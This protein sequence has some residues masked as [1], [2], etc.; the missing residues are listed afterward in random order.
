MSGTPRNERYG[1]SPASRKYLNRGCSV[2]SA[3]RLRP[4]LLGDQPG[5]PFGE[6]HPHAADALG[7]QADRRRQHQVRAIGLEQVHRADVGLE[8]PLDQVDDVGQRLRRVAALR[9]QAADF[10]ERPETAIPPGL[11]TACSDGAHG[12]LRCVAEPAEQE[13]CPRIGAQHPGKLRVVARASIRHVL[14]ARR[15]GSST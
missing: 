3:T 14:S 15:S 11:V 2:A 10:F 7:P 8:P 4:Q 12:Y 9:D 5:Q 13:R 6:P 1:S